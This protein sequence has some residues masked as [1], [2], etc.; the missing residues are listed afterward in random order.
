MQIKNNGTIQVQHTY[1][2]QCED[3]RHTSEVVYDFVYPGTSITKHRDE[4]KDEQD[5]TGIPLTTPTN[6]AKRGTQANKNKT[7]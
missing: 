3:R 7:I 6:E 5:R 4:M 2:K 1:W